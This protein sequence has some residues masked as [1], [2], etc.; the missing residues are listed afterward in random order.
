MR[1]MRFFMDRIFLYSK[2]PQRC[3]SVGFFWCENRGLIFTTSFQNTLY[4]IFFVCQVFIKSK[5]IR[6]Q[7]KSP[8]ILTFRR[9]N[10]IIILNTNKIQKKICAEIQYKPVFNSCE[11]IGL[12]FFKF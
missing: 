3:N 9:L 11:I 4:H 7:D 1:S 8:P 5:K 12:I 6:T 10:S 2:T